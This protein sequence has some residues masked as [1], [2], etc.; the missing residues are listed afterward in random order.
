MSSESVCLS[1][2]V[3]ARLNTKLIQTWFQS[4][5]KTWWSRGIIFDKALSASQATEPDNAVALARVEIKHANDNIIENPWPFVK[6]NIYAGT[7]RRD[8]MLCAQRN[9]TAYL[10][11]GANPQAHQQSTR[12]STHHNHKHNS[13]TLVFLKHVTDSATTEKRFKKH[14]VPY[15]RL[16]SAY[17]NVYWK[18]FAVRI[19]CL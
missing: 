13:R 10:K 11:L 5:K 9:K 15:G 7:C 6:A 12:Q 3:Y 4:A 19:C 8:M 16:L 2:F 18:E 17:A 1:L 14:L